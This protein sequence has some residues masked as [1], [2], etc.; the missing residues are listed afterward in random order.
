MN[1]L[2][3]E[4]AQLCSYFARR[5]EVEEAWRYIDAIEQAWHESKDPP[6]MAEYQAGTWGPDEADELMRQ[7]ERRWRRL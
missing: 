6:A 7:D 2:C 1:D 3:L 4:C 5:D